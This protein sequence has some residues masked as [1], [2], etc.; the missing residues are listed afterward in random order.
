MIYCKNEVH[1]LPL[2]KYSWESVDR[3][4][5]NLKNFVSHWYGRKFIYGEMRDKENNEVYHLAMT[6]HFPRYISTRKHVPVVCFVCDTLPEAEELLK[7]EGFD[8]A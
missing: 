5:Y 4:E 3:P 2:R 7:R 8:D 1:Q 6:R